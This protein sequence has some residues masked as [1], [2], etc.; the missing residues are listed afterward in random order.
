MRLSEAQILIVPGLGNSGPDHWQSR[1]EDRMKTAKR[2]IVSDWDNPCPEKWPHAV[3]KNVAKARKPVV[4]V[5]H[6]LGVLS[7]IHAI[8]DMDTRK[9]AGAFLVAMPDSE[10]ETRVPSSVSV[11]GAIPRA[12]LPFKASLIASRTDPYCAFDKAE[13]IAGHWGAKLLDAGDAGHI[14][15]DSGQGPWPEGLLN[16]ATFMKEL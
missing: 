9:V 5:G 14:N 15:A 11:F 16:F 2:V 6:S 7:I 12:A 8:P 10:T 3:V 1:W 13:E 4:L